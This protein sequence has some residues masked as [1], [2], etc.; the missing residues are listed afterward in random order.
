MCLTM[1]FCCSKLVAKLFSLSIVCCAVCTCSFMLLKACMLIAAEEDVGCFTLKNETSFCTE[2]R[3][4]DTLVCM[5]SNSAIVLSILAL[6]MFV[7][8]EVKPCADSVLLALISCCCWLD[9]CAACCGCGVDTM[10]FCTGVEVEAGTGVDAP[11][12]ESAIFCCLLIVFGV[13]VDE[14]LQEA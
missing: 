12:L 13:Y 10:V 1:L 5:C 11:L 6:L 8:D 4:A 3:A 2:L 14:S 7:N 9:C